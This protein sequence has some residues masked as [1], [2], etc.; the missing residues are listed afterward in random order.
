MRLLLFSLPLL[1]KLS[2]IELEMQVNG[3][4]KWRLARTAVFH[5][6]LPYL[7]KMRRTHVNLA[8]AGPPNHLHALALVCKCAGMHVS[9][10]SV[11]HQ[12]RCL[13]VAHMNILEH[14]PLTL[15]SPAPCMS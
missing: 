5:S 12:M 4:G 14:T 2:V 9:T 13:L 1:R 15:F 6:D 10:D 3:C 11:M 7:N 8:Q